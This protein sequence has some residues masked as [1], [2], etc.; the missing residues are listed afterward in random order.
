MLGPLPRRKSDAWWNRDWP[1]RIFLLRELSAVAV[2]AYVVVLLLLYGAMASGDEDRYLDVLGHPAMVALHVV[3][4]AFAVLHTATWFRA[5]PKGLPL[6][7]GGRRV[8]AGMLILASYAAWAAVS[9]VVLAVVLVG[10]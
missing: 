1:Y 8:P 4:L 9:A 6:K 2:A 10:S 5:L 7:I 3:V